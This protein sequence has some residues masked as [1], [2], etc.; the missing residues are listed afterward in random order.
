MAYFCSI[1]YVIVERL[2]L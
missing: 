1:D 2:Q